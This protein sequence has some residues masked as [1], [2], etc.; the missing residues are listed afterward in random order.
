MAQRKAEQERDRDQ[1]VETK[2]ER[3]SERRRKRVTWRRGGV[4][5]RRQNEDE[6]EVGRHRAR[7]NELV[8]GVCARYDVMCLQVGPKHTCMASMQAYHVF[9]KMIVF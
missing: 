7:G 2:S 8:K 4:E 6:S 1:Y 5:A 3:K 9:S